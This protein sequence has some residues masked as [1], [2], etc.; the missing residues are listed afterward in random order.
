MYTAGDTYL[1]E[2]YTAGDTYLTEI[3]LS[4]TQK[5]GDTS[6]VHGVNS[7]TNVV[8]FIVMETVYIVTETRHSCN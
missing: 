5:V 8:E 4:G 2:M 7:D 3:I 1:T 6:V